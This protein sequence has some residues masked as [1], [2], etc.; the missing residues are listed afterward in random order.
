MCSDT[1]FC[2]RFCA[3][4]S[5]VGFLFMVRTSWPT[6]CMVRV[7]IGSSR[8]GT[9][10]TRELRSQHRWIPMTRN[11]SD[12]HLFLLVPCVGRTSPFFRCTAHGSH[13]ADP[14]TTYSRG[15]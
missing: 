8:A 6:V 9:T 15:H 3:L 14:S 4:Y 12:T 10:T 7:R 13:D 11:F 5:V 2:A 1:R